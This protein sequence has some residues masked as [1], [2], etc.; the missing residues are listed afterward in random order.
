MNCLFVQPDVGLPAAA[1]EARRAAMELRAVVLDGEVTSADLIDAIHQV[2]PELVA[3]ATHG[4]EA[5]I[6]L[7][8]G[9]IG[10]GELVADLRNA[11]ARCVFLNT[12]SSRDLVRELYHE[13]GATAIGTVRDVADGLAYRTM[14]HFLHNVAAGASWR[15]AYER[16]K[17]GQNRDYVIFPELPDMDPETRQLLASINERLGRMDAKFDRV[18]E[19]LSDVEKRLTSRIERLAANSVRLTARNA[20][21]WLAGFLSFILALLVLAPLVPVI[22]REVG[23]SP[24][25]IPALVVIAGLLALLSAYL[26][27]SGIGFSFGV[28]TKED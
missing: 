17:P 3:F 16:S 2:R 18:D 5:G 1:K 8:D 13:L 21:Q 4:S 20:L 24:A 27:M 10:V 19:R 9:I 26:L 22:A 15:E 14:A 23:M 12:C 7:S 11:G 25:V 28:N 6:Q